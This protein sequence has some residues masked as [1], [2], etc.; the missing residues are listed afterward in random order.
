MQKDRVNANVPVERLHVMDRMAR[1]LATADPKP[2]SSKM[3]ELEMRREA[4][5]RAREFVSQRIMRG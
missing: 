3:D 4:Y 1:N 2:D 5:R